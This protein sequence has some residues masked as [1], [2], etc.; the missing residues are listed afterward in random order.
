MTSW[1]VPSLL[2]CKNCTSLLH[3]GCWFDV[4]MCHWVV[5]SFLGTHTSMPSLTSVEGSLIQV[6]QFL[7]CLRFLST[8]TL[9]GKKSHF[10]QNRS[11]MNYGAL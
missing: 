6:S 1:E 4:F 2:P 10:W 5:R 8:Y 11:L 9:G 7:S 3:W